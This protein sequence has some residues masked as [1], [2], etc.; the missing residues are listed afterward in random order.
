[1]IAA[2]AI[3]PYLSERRFFPELAQDVTHV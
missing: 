2:L 3:H 1:M